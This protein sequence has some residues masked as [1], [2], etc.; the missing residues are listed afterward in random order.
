[1][2]GQNM[3]LKSEYPQSAEGDPADSVVSAAC[4]AV[5]SE[6]IDGMFRAF[7][8][9]TRLRIL[10]LLL[11]G[12]TCVGDIVQILEVPQPR[13]SRHLGY[14]RKTGLVTVRK[15]RQWSYY[16]LRPAETPFHAKLL[17]CL[18]NCFADVPELKADQQRARAL[19]AS[20]QCCCPPPTTANPTHHGATT[21]PNA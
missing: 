3:D 12:E 11:G 9:R 8:D 21:G 2:D 17:E 10:Q 16:S 7:S 14:L 19:R 1:M 20:G 18:A 15:S 6:D 4:Q 5:L 13:A